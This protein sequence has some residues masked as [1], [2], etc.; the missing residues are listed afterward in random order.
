MPPVHNRLSERIG[1]RVPERGPKNIAPLPPA[2]S[3]PQGARQDPRAKKV[4]SYNDLDSS[5]PSGEGE[6]DY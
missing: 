5:V 2:S 1:D 6:L 4:A 3:S